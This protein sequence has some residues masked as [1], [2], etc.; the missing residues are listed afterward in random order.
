MSNDYEY[1]SL[2][3][4]STVLK[5][6]LVLGM[7]LSLGAAGSSYLQLDMLERAV[8][9]G[10]DEDEAEAN[11][12]RETVVSLPG[13]AVY[14]MTAIVFGMWIYRANGNVRALGARGLRHTPG[15]AVGWF[16]V[17]ILNLWK[18]CEAMNDLYRASERVHGWQKRQSPVVIVVW[19]I[20]WIISGVLGQA[21]GRIA[22]RAETL[23]QLKLATNI[24]LVSD[25]FDV[26]LA[27]VALLL[28]TKIQ[29]HQAVAH[30]PMSYPEDEW[31]ERD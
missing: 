9:V 19:W 28:V 31:P 26:P 12:F 20:C 5:V 13:L 23:P 6:L 2:T 17:P 7:F 15:W 10:V 27:L 25:C 4:R 16:F 8:T 29:T 22:L 30:D 18:P 14:I 21:A 3:G 11:D 1:L 24:S